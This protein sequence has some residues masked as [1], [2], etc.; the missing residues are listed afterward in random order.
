MYME[1]EHYIPLRVRYWDDFG[2]EVK[3][4]T[5]SPESIRSFGKLWIAT[6]STMRDLRQQTHSTLLVEDVD[7]EPNF[8]PRLFSVTLLYKGK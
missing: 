8:H 4:M 6:K 2:V 1:K 3:E 5:A 7:T